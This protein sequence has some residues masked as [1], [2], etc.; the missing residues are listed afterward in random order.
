MD[1]TKFVGLFEERY[2]RRPRLFQAPGR[3][4]LIGEH[5]DYND[6]FVFPCAIDRRTVVAIAARPDNV[7]RARSVGFDGVAEFRLDA[8]A[9]RANHWSDYVQGVVVELLAA[10]VAMTG[11]DLLIESDVPLGAGLSSSAAIEVATA[12]AFLGMSGA[13]MSTREVALLCQRAEN[14]FVGAPCGIMDQFASCH[15]RSGHALLIDCRTLSVEGVPLPAGHSIVVCNS[16]VR[17]SVGGGEYG[18]RR[19][20]CEEAA[21]RLGV[22]ALRDVGVEEF[23]RRADEL[24]NVVRKRAR[25]VVTENARALA[26]VDAL[27]A[28]DTIRFGKLMNESHDSLRR[29]FEAS[30]DE[31]DLLVELARG[32]RGVAGARMTGGGFGGCTVNLV[33]RGDADAMR[34]SVAAAYRART[35]IAA[36]TYEFTASAGAGEVAL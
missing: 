8:A 13:A 24:P 31:L 18:E 25:H 28:G 11:A 1:L 3:V 5:T 16:M 23:E 19:R 22:K 14:R 6:G 29:D 27:R 26:A 30:C 2:Q 36:E 32:T 35:G 34:E 4:N 12:R 17:H 10:G 7:V 21:R 33:L 9:T 15:G 20:A